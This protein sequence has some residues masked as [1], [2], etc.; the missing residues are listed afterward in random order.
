MF[1][2]FFNEWIYN[3]HQ[4]RETNNHN[5]ERTQSENDSEHPDSV[6]S[7][8]VWRPE[9][10][11]HGVWF[12]VGSMVAGL[13]TYGLTLNFGKHWIGLAFGWIMVNLGMIATTV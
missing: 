6:V 12:P 11:L 9:Y 10:R 2:Y 7:S 3:T 4:R 5:L 1:G 13:L 8:S